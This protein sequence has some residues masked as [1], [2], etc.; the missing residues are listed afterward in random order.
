M[1]ILQ[2]VIGEFKR[3]KQRIRKERRI[4]EYKPQSEVIYSKVFK[5]FLCYFFSVF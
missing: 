3:V 4:K 5:S 2:F 1:R